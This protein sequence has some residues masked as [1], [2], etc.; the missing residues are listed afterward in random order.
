MMID[1]DQKNGARPCGACAPTSLCRRPV[2]LRAC[3]SRCSFQERAL[4]DLSYSWWWRGIREEH[5]P[6]GSGRMGDLRQWKFPGQL[7]IS[8]FCLAVGC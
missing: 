6:F 3:R 5:M 4:P 7:Q 8:V 2:F 1:P